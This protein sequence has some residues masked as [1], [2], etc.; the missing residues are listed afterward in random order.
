MSKRAWQIQQVKDRLSEVVDL[1]LAEGP[2]TI[3]RH[4]KKVAVIVS[5][6]DFEKRRRAGARGTVLPFLR[7]LRL[8]QLDVERSRDVDREIDL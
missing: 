3:T 4:G 8:G 5:I 2:Q 1:A 6:E 7:K